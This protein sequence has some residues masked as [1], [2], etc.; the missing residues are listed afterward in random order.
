MTNEE[1]IKMLKSKMDGNTDTSY[2]WAETVRMAIL[3]LEVQ[4]KT[5]RWVKLCEWSTKPV[6]SC[7]GCFNNSKYKNYCPS[8]GSRMQNE[9]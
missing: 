4:P 5:G 9:R 2:K 7:C 3:A 8:C 1:A 6:C